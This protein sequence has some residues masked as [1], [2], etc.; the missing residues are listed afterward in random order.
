MGA[1]VYAAIWVGICLLTA[2][3]ADF[4]DFWFGFLLACASHFACLCMFC[5]RY[6]S[7]EVCV[8]SAVMVNHEGREV[9]EDGERAWYLFLLV[10]CGVW[11]SCVKNGPGTRYVWVQRHRGT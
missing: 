2:D 4:A 8:L 5:F 7:G 9:H 10:F 6:R 1:G 3:Y 11:R